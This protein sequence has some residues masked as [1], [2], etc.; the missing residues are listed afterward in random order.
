MAAIPPDPSAD[1]ANG[2]PGG[3]LGDRAALLNPSRA[4]P[5]FF[6]R[7]ETPILG[8]AAPNIVEYCEEL[9]EMAR[10]GKIRSLGVVYVDAQA[11]VGTGY[12]TSGMPHAPHLIA[13]AVELLRRCEENWK[14]A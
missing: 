2:G 13:G 14:S 11:Y 3:K 7:K 8:E 5:I 6:F 1:R 12:A 9:L 10:S 4:F